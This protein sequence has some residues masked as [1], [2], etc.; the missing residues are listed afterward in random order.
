[1]HVR[2]LTYGYS[3]KGIYHIY[4]VTQGKKR[5]YD[6]AISVKIVFKTC[7]WTKYVKEKCSFELSDI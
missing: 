4:I 6:S 7:I 3:R 1:M 5:M 2:S